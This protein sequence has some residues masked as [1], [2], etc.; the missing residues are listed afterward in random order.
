MKRI[1]KI[2]IGIA[3]VL[4]L[5]QFIQPARNNS[6]SVQSTDLIKTIPVP[7]H[8]QSILK[9]ACYDCHSNNTNYP[10]YSRIQPVGWLLERHIRNGKAELNFSEFGSISIR[11]RIS[12]LNEMA[13]SIKDRTMPLR[14]YTMIHKNARLSTKDKAQLI[15]WATKTEDSLKLKN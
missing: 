9:T 1:K 14:S 15:D 6:N 10:W 4:I 8:V 7:E 12:K 3:I 2:L 11:R 13:N 5:M